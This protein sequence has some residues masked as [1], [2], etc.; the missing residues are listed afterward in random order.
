MFR[1]GIMQNRPI[2]DK[3]AVHGPDDVPDEGPSA[4]VSN[5]CW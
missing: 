4:G 2:T 3:P 5:L 1:F